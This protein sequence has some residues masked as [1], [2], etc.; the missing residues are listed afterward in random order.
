MDEKKEAENEF[1]LHAALEITVRRKHL[2]KGKE[3][4]KKMPAECHKE[5][6]GCLYLGIFIHA[7]K[8]VSSPLA[9]I[10]MAVFRRHDGRAELDVDRSFHMLTKAASAA[11]CCSN[12]LF[13]PHISNIFGSNLV[14][15]M[16]KVHGINQLLPLE[17]LNMV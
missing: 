16:N 10:Y 17:D 2:V 13:L 12:Y 7:G 8:V 15:L 1:I 9:F 6:N 4:K 3:E 5:M 14:A 11:F